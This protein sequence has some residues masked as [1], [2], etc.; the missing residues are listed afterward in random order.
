M[1]SIG[2]ESFLVKD[3]CGEG[4]EFNSLDLANK[5]FSVVL[6]FSS[7]SDTC[8]DEVEE[9]D[10]VD[11]LRTGDGDRLSGD[12]ETLAGSG[13]GDFLFS[14]GDGDFLFSWG[15]GDLSGDQVCATMTLSGVLDLDL[16]DEL[17]AELKK[18]YFEVKTWNHFKKVTALL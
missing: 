5:T 16:E 3:F 17:D 18:K 14:S 10:E 6:S 7:G 15:E 1:N 2:T 13:D 8:T 12:G 4:W 11:D 9:D